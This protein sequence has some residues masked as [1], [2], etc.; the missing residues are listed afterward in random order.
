MNSYM[1]P[2]SISSWPGADRYLSM[3]RLFGPQDGLRPT[4]GS[5]NI[6]QPKVFFVDS[7]NGSDSAGGLSPA[8]AKATIGGAIAAAVTNR[9]D[10]ILVSDKHTETLTAAIAMS[11]AGITVMGCGNARSRPTLTNNP[12]ATANAMLVSGADCRVLNIVFAASSATSTSH[13]SVTGANCEIGYCEFDQGGSD[14]DSVILGAGSQRSNIHDCNWRVTANGPVEA[15][16][17]SSATTSSGIRM[18]RLRFFGMNVTNMWDTACI[19]S[20][21]AHLDC[22]VNDVI[23]DFGMIVSFSSATSTGL[24]KDAFGGQLG[25]AG[26][27]IR[28]GGCALAGGPMEGY[29]FRLADAVLPQGTTGAIGTATGGRVAY[30]IVAQVGTLIGGADNFKYI[31]HPAA[32]TDVDPAALVDINT[33]GEAGSLVG[34]SATGLA[35]TALVHNKAGGGAAAYGLGTMPKLLASG[36]ILRQ[37]HVGSVTG[38][39]KF[40]VWW[41]P[42]DPGASF[43]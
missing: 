21:V 20:S 13:I 41:R 3:M 35:A 16:S 5:S 8:T 18:E 30:N 29:L 32:G 14:A 42:V 4:D 36:A 22:L 19:V 25:A 31:H 17:I 26:N 12:A 27:Q 23:T 10:V 24:I 40:D 7:V 11:K 15:I 2:L 43:V 38:S 1:D 9:G 39:L 28:I 33:N 34:F 6:N 37:N